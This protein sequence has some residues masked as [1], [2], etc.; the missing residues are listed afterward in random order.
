MTTLL[1]YALIAAGLY[2]IGRGAAGLV[3][4]A[5][6]VARLRCRRRRTGRA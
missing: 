4:M 1:G 3:R 6:A 2:L 5:W